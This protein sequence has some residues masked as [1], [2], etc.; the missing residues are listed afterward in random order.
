M[1][2]A[3][4]WEGVLP[5]VVEYDVVQMHMLHTSSI[6]KTIAFFIFGPLNLCR[7]QL[8]DVFFPAP[9][10][11]NSPIKEAWHWYTT[12][13]A[14]GREKTLLWSCSNQPTLNARA[15]IP[16]CI[17]IQLEISHVSSSKTSI[18]LRVSISQQHKGCQRT[19]ANVVLFLKNEYNS[20]K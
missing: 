1:T 16:S 12:H 19:D 8:L 2:I 15:I 9:W 14:R 10:K 13:S 6:A 5:L 20:K 17:I 4:F 11:N 18:T 3:P 7:V